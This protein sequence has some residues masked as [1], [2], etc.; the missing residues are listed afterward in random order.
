[1]V[2]EILKVLIVAI[3]KLIEMFISLLPAIFEIIGLPKKMFASIIG[4]PVIVLTL[5]IFIVKILKKYYKK[6][7]I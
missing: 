2:E 6:H 5:L 4:V 1:M 3:W 7:L